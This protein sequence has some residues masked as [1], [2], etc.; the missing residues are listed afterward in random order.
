MK[1]RNWLQ[2]A[3]VAALVL[4]PFYRGMLNMPGFRRMHTPGSIASLALSLILNLVLLSFVNAYLGNLL[5]NSRWTWLRLLVPALVLGSFAEMVYV[6]DRGWESTRVWT[7]SMA[8][9]LILTLLLHWCW[10]RGEKLLLRLSGALL[11]GLGFY[12][13][14]V[15]AQLL[16]FT[17]WHQAP[18]SISEHVSNL[19]K[20]SDRPRIIWILFDELSYVQT[21]GDRYPGL[22]L[23]NFDQFRKTATLFTDVQP[24]VNETEDAIPAILQGVYVDRV[25]YDTSNHLKIGARSGSFQA[26][27]ASRT[28]FALAHQNGLST[29]L[30]GW[31]NPYCS[32]LAPYVNRCYW[33]DEMQETSAFV[34]RGFLQDFLHPW[35][36]YAQ[37]FAHP[38]KILSGNYRARAIEDILQPA[39]LEKLSNL[40]YRAK[41]YKDLLSR[42]SELVRPSGLDFVFIHLPLPHPPGF[43]DRNTKQITTSGLNS[44]VD[45]LAL[46]DETLGRLLELLRQSPR[47]GRTS[48]VICGDH[49]W[50]TYLWTGASFW[51]PEDQAASHGGVFDSRPLLMIHLAGQTTPATVS[52]P[53]P[54]LRVH[55]ILDDLVTGKRPT[56]PVEQAKDI[57]QKDPSS[58]L[59]A[60]NPCPVNHTCE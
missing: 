1:F 3:G 44:Y 11:V 47:W 58:R 14:L 55:D 56:F 31:Y 45:N 53:F 28:P 2:G 37:I 7:W 9:T 5:R 46:T 29:G 16:Y 17:T 41:V 21:F 60:T 40:A 48:I 50:R 8:C 36:L 34:R 52:E 10:R 49:S 42:D 32:M 59:K 18:N 39:A 23:P 25:D 22:K 38:R 15:I 57:G 33:T 19:T 24:I 43:Y 12:C 26:F 27:D 13:I 54:L 6:A 30:A 4:F 20:D 35:I 51:T